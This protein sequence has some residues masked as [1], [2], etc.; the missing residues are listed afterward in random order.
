MNNQTKREEFVKSIQHSASN[1]NKTAL[2]PYIPS[3]QIRQQTFNR[4]NE[5]YQ[6]YSSKEVQNYFHNI[7]AAI[8]LEYNKYFSKYGY[9]IQ[10]FYRFKSPKSLSEKIAEYT[11]RP[12]KYKMNFNIQ[13]TS[14]EQLIS[15]LNDAA[16]L[17]VVLVKSPSS[18]PFR[19]NEKI[20]RLLS[21]KNQNE[22]FLDNMREF[23]TQLIKTDDLGFETDEYEYK[24]AKKDYYSNCIKVL[25][26]IISLIPKEAAELVQYYNDKKETFMSN[27]EIIENMQIDGL[28]NDLLVDESDYPVN[29]NSNEVDFTTLLNDLSERINDNL[30][31]EILNMQMENILSRSPIVKDL[32]LKLSSS[33]LKIRDNGYISFFNVLDTPI[34][35]VELQNQTHRAYIDGNIGHSAHTKMR[36]SKKIKPAKIPNPSDSEAVK[37]FKEEV[38][39]VSP[40]YFS[41]KMDSEEKNRVLISGSS[42]YNNYR[43]VISEVPKGSVQSKMLDKYF[44]K[45]YKNQSKIFND[46]YKE[47]SY[48]F[49]VPDIKRFIKK[50]VADLNNNSIER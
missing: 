24:V 39:Y 19:N 13:G 17:K 12:N 37:K 40:K 44:Q 16:A 28:D 14:P 41:A 25:D 2:G 6:T 45:L 47:E 49:T 46:G 18:P 1:K 50:L 20:S 9:E 21:E 36:S 11:I 4:E 22:Q 27:I 26:T 42:D 33:K 29:E 48:S 30:D 7:V 34:G 3:I 10:I 5:K 31:F 43:K 8:M 32:G 15:K 35:P 23:E 38:H